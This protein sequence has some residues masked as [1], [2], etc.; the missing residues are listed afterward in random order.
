MLSFECDRSLVACLVACHCSGAK[1]CASAG[2]LRDNIADRGRARTDNASW[3]S[4][5]QRLTS[6]PCGVDRV[7]HHVYNPT[8]VRRSSRRRLGYMTIKCYSHRVPRPGS[9]FYRLTLTGNSV[10]KKPSDYWLI[11]ISFLNHLT[12]NT[13]LP[14][15]LVVRRILARKVS[16]EGAINQAPIDAEHINNTVNTLCMNDN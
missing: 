16:S 7:R 11:D 15:A 8:V 9:R 2:R 4:R 5:K 3:L 12:F 13:G 1:L 6:E 14:K 10:H